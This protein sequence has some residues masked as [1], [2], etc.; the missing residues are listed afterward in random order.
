KKAQEGVNVR[1]LYDDMGSRS[2]SRGYIRRLEAA[3]INVGAFFPP[4]IPKL[5]FKINFRNHCK[6]AIIDGK[7]GYIAGINIGDEYIGD[8]DKFGYWRETHLRGKG[9]AV[10]TMQTRFI[11]DWNQ[12]SRNHI[13]Y[14]ERYIIGGNK[15]ETGM[16]IDSSGPDQEWE[17]INYGYSNMI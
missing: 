6:L 14:D 3:G 15:R 5:N 9:D 8:T 17:Q 4:K 16:Q 12:T 10:K 11:L 1:F 13:D 2:L 7:I